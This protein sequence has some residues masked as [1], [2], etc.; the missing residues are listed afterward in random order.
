M[1]KSLESPTKL[2]EF[3]PLA[4]P[5]SQQQSGIRSTFAR[6][7]GI[8]NK[9]PPPTIKEVVNGANE[10]P[11]PPS[12]S[13]S[14]DDISQSGESTVSNITYTGEGG[15]PVQYCEGRTLVSVLTR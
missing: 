4:P 1:A 10:V 5:E 8:N 2:T 12:R 15:L 14:R 13:S 6:W 7:F 3:A 11:C 9:N